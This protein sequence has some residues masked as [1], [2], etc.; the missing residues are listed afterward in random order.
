SPTLLSASAE[1]SKILEI[2]QKLDSLG[3][4]H[5]KSVTAIDLPQ[6][7]KIDIVYHISSFLDVELAKVIFELR[8]SLNR[9]DPKVASV[10]DIWPSAEYPERETLDLM[11]VTFEGMPEKERLFLMDNFEGGP[12]LRKDF[13]LKVE[14]IDA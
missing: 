11:G 4:D 1:R 12:P 8:T 6:E 14:G 13:K 10:F 5:V 7:N 2:A 9:Q 3:F